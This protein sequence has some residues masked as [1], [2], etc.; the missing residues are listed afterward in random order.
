M[1]GEQTLPIQIARMNVPYSHV[2]SSILSRL[3]VSN[4][5]SAVG[6]LGSRTYAWFT[7]PAIDSPRNTPCRCSATGEPIAWIAPRA[8][9]PGPPPPQKDDE[10]SGAGG[11]YAF[12]ETYVLRT[13]APVLPLNEADTRAQ[14][15]EVILIF[16]AAEL[17]RERNEHR[18]E[19][20][21][22]SHGGA[23]AE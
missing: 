9:L 15:L 14:P 18:A 3:S 12:L 6:V 13:P 2:S 22:D 16:Q 8:A 7:L 11:R 19:Q 20:R 21:R 1:L 17:A 10:S 4:R 23:E 5:A